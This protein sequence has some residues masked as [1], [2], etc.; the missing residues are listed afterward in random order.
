MFGI[1]R[2][3]LNKMLDKVPSL[4][5]D[6]YCKGGIYNATNIKQ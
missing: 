2:T 4:W 6:L 3:K 5:Y 1:V